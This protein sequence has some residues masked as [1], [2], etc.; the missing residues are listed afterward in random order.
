MFSI[1]SRTEVDSATRYRCCLGALLNGVSVFRSTSCRNSITDISHTCSSSA[2]RFMK[3][4]IYHLEL[5]SLTFLFHERSGLSASVFI[6]WIIKI[7]LKRSRRRRTTTR[8]KE[9]KELEGSIMIIIEGQ[10]LHPSCF[11]FI[12]EQNMFLFN[13][14]SNKNMIS[15]S[16]KYKLFFTCFWMDI[17]VIKEYFEHVSKGGTNFWTSTV[18]WFYLGFLALV[19]KR[20]NN[21]T[22]SFRIVRDNDL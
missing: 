12:K 2:L 3:E 5:T 20:D 13:N 18:L 21:E 6:Y 7:I 16:Y 11:F 10:C 22:C 9:D 19:V 15:P 14:S 4:I 1:G 8:K 17:Q